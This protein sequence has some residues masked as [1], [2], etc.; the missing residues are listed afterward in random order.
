MNNLLV[1]LVALCGAEFVHN[2]IEIWGMRQKVSWLALAQDGQEHGRWPIN[3]DTKFKTIVL[4][5]S[6]LLLFAGLFCVVL[7]TLNLSDRH[8]VI[9]GIIILLINYICT[10]WCVD[11]YHSQ[12]GKLI[13]KAKSNS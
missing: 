12:I 8:L 5:G 7:K 6:I 9:A 4:H 1:V 11:V 13:K 3:L 2:N 10:T